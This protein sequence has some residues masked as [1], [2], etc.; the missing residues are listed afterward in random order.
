MRCSSRS[1]AYEC[2]V[3]EVTGGEPLLQKDVYPLMQRLLADAADRAARDRRPS[4]RRATSRPACI[5]SSTSSARAAASRRR[6]HWANLDDAARRPTKSNSSSRTAATT[7]TPVDSSRDRRC[8]RAAR[9]FC[10]PPC[11]ACSMPASW[12][13]GSSQ[14]VLPVRLQLQAHKYI[15]DPSTRGCDGQRGSPAPER[16]ARLLHG[17]RDR[18][19]EG[20]ELYALTVRYG[21]VHAREIEAARQVARALGVAGTSS[22]MFRSRRSAGRRS[23]ATA[24]SP[25]TGTLIPTGIPSTYVPARNTVFLSLALGVGGGRRC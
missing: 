17:R 8:R 21:Q 9:P 18:R 1:R 11:T 6:M 25:K 16:R 12:R 15:W 4:Q 23:S 24:R 19:A 2:D 7:S 20:Y 13:S 5:G 3:V 22:W 10:F 14:T